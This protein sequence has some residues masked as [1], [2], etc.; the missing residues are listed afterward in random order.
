MAHEEIAHRF[1][2]EVFFRLQRQRAVSTWIAILA[3]GSRSP[4]S[5]PWWGCCR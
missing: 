1:E 3:L 2:D 4:L 5:P